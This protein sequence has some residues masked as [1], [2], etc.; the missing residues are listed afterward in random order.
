MTE[1][2]TTAEI[3]TDIVLRVECLNAERKALADDVKEVLK[4]GKRH[5]LDVPRIREVIKIRDMKPKDRA[6]L[7]IGNAT[8]T[9]LHAVETTEKDRAARKAAEAAST[10][11]PKV[12]P[13]P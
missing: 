6:E 11:T 12:E 7:T 4:D 13:A 2:R 9:Y 3:L 10:S 8:A 1:T 5:A